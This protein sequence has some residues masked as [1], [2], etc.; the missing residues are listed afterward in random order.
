M[1]EWILASELFIAAAAVVWRV[2]YVS[3]TFENP[4]FG[5]IVAVLH[6]C[7]VMMMDETFGGGVVYIT[8]HDFVCV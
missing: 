4:Q 5:I 7:V 6:A 8:L 2:W 1:M 3:D